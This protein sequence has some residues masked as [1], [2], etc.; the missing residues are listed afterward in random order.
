MGSGYAFSEVYLVKWA[1]IRLLR[2]SYRKSA[3]GS[4]PLLK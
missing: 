2:S 3:Q 1:A 4:L